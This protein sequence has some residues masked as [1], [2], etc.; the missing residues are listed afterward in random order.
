V[1]SHRIRANAELPV[2]IPVAVPVTTNVTTKVT[3]KV[4]AVIPI[5]AVAI[6]VIA[7]IVAV[8]GGENVRDSHICSSP[9]FREL[10]SG[11]SLMC[12]YPALC[13]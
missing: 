3:A 6:V 12:R 8:A 11:R 10:F 9:R 13:W 7:M 4:T 2:L 1:V 5:M